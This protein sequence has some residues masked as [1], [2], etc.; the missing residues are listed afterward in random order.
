MCPK[1]KQTSSICGIKME[2][3]SLTLVLNVFLKMFQY[4]HGIFTEY[5]EDKYRMYFLLNFISSRNITALHLSLPMYNLLTSTNIIQII[6][7][8]YGSCLS[9]GLNEK[10]KCLLIISAF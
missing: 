10:E 1:I 8:F 9:G 5:I 3:F 4:F 7:M 6:V 2:I